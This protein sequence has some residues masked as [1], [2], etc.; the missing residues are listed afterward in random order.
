MKHFVLL[1][2]IDMIFT[3]TNYIIYKF[4]SML[5]MYYPNII[6]TDVEIKI[7][8][9]MVTGL[10]SMTVPCAKTTTSVKY[11]I[12]TSRHGNGFRIAVPGNASVDLMCSLL[13]AWTGYWTNIRF[14]CV[15]RRIDAH[16]TSLL[17]H[18]GLDWVLYKVCHFA[19]LILPTQH[20][21]VT[22]KSSMKHFCYRNFHIRK[23]NP[24]LKQVFIFASHI[25]K[26]FT[27]LV[28]IR[29]FSIKTS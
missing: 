19:R 21:S 29:I 26:Q 14:L 18:L 4:E 16:L 20:N 28:Q 10:K 25:H 8:T 17:W 7:V 22:K 11:T 23:Q 13:L 24:V 15:Q 2:P 12:M 9:K 6:L 3:L 1:F 5:V 27:N